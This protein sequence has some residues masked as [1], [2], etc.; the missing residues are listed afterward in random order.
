MVPSAPVTGF[1]RE[2][3]AGL[4]RPGRGIPGSPTGCEDLTP[5]VVPVWVASGDEYPTLDDT[6]VGGL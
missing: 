3:V 1:C 5:D 6:K 4:G 2:S